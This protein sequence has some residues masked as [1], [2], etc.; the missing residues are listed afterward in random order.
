MEGRYAGDDEREE[1][2]P[3]W[4]RHDVIEYR[5]GARQSPRK[6]RLSWDANG[7][8]AALVTRPSFRFSVIV[9]GYKQWV[10]AFIVVQFTRVYPEQL[11]AVAPSE[12][13]VKP[14][15]LRSRCRL[16]T[17]NHAKD[18]IKDEVGQSTAQHGIDAVLRAPVE[19]RPRSEDALY[20]C[21]RKGV[22]AH[23][24]R[25]SH[26]KTPDQSEQNHR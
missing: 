5:Q 21:D 20:E 15:S 16:G 1:G 18:G 9:E 4:R 24:H 11:N 8:E 23:E 22:R 19:L 2:S 25:R 12:L 17:Y 10:P 7:R 26:R 6:I 13:Q 3:E 14:F